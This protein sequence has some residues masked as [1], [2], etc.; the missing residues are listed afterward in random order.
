MSAT[1]TRVFNFDLPPYPREGIFHLDMS[2]NCQVTRLLKFEA[3]R[4][5]HLNQLDVFKDEKS[6]K[7]FQKKLRHTLWKKLGVS[8]DSSLP[9]NIREYGT[10]SREDF[11]IRKLIY[12]SQPGVYVTALLYVPNGKGPF[13]GVI[14][15]HGHNPE[16]KFGTNVQSLSLGLVKSGYV[17]LAVDAFGT[18]ERAY[19]CYHNQNHGNFQGSQFLN[20]GETL[21]GVQVVDNMRGVDLLRSLPFVIKNKIGAAGASGGGNQTMWLAALDERIAAAVPVVSVGS[22]E[23]YV[24]GMNCMCELLPDGLTMTE[25]SGILALIAPRPLRIGNALYDCNHDFSVSQMLKTFHPVE[26]IYWNLGYPDRISCHVADRVHGMHDRQRESVLGFFA[27]FLKEEGSG[28]PLPEPEYKL[29]PEEQLH[30][31]SAE[32]ER[33]EEVMTIPVYLQKK[34]TLLRKQFLA[35]ENIDRKQAVKELK[36][37]LRLP[38]EPSVILHK[39]TEIN[40]IGRY[41]A[42]AGNHIIPF[43]TISGKQHGKYRI[44]LHPDGKKN[45]T[46]SEIEQAQQDGATLILPDLF[47]CGETCQENAT[48]G[49]HH[50]FFR[51][52]LWVGHSLI[53]EWTLDVLSLATAIKKYFKAQEISAAGLLES[54]AAALFANVFS[55]DINHV[56]AINCP[57]SLLFDCSSISLTA[58]SAF[59]K[60]LPGAIYSLTLGIPGFLKWG[61]IS[62]AAALGTGEVRFISP[63]SSDG[64]PMSPEAEKNFA[65]E[66]VKIKKKL[67]PSGE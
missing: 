41:A 7:L 8:Y 42:E 29:F 20:I 49:L 40:G 58:R 26:K 17:V 1:E 37:L 38:E 46:Q 50:Q 23:S 9:L 15:M 34:G 14:H 48:I 36:R 19:E 10:L 12:Q 11:S 62:L 53:G 63:R 24:Y 35:R 28:N 52:L 51:Q 32:R 65:S 22:F 44:L 55:H 2:D 59:D 57:A 25:E 33:P 67:S 5:S 39:Y 21:M 4:L 18:Y 61:D 3:G 16:G 13:P 45:I 6:L 27:R 47:G 30:L 64:T 43:L 54:G 66:I 56:E 60:Y 31:F